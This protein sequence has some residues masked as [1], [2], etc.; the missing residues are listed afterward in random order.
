MHTWNRESIFFT[1][2]LSA[3]VSY[4]I[5]MSFLKIIQQTER[6]NNE[7]NK[8]YVDSELSKEKRQLVTIICLTFIGNG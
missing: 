1:S 7:E 8:Q 6:N 2:V 3:N 5:F 4:D